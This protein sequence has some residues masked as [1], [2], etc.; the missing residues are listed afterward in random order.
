MKH[1]Q[2]FI[3]GTSR[4]F[5]LQTATKSCLCFDVHDKQEE[6]HCLPDDA[7]DARFASET[8]KTLGTNRE[9]HTLS[10]RRKH[11]HVEHED[12]APGELDCVP[13]VTY[14][15]SHGSHRTL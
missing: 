6:T 12:A 10:A 13:E 8:W 3:D 5:G 4:L 7:G 15:V 9:K 1:T 11:L 2:L 14:S